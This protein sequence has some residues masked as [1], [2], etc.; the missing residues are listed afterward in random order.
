M[1][2]A[3]VGLSGF[4]EINPANVTAVVGENVTFDCITD[5]TVGS[6]QWQVEPEFGVNGSDAAT[7]ICSGSNVLLLKP[8]PGKYE[9][10]SDANTHSLSIRNL[11]LNDSGT[12]VCVANGTH[13]PGKGCSQLVVSRKYRL[14]LQTPVAF[15]SAFF[16][17]KAVVATTSRLGFD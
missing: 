17:F 2:S 1:T 9:F 4:I 11:S 12:Y 10:T 14:I 16:S 6:V 15:R 7:S 3:C 8:I 13:G 5:S